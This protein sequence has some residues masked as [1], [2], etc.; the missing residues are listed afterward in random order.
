MDLKE[1][2]T[3]LPYIGFGE[4]R[5]GG[6]IENQDSWGYE[7]TPYGLLITVCDGMGGGPGGKTASSI[8]VDAIKNSVKEANSE[9]AIINIVIKAIRNANMAIIEKT[10]E[11]PALKGMGSTCLVLLINEKSAIAAHVGD[12]RIYQFRGHRKVFRTFDHSM[13]FELVKKKVIT[14]EQAR[15]SAQ[16][17][18]ITRALGVKPDVEVDVRQLPYLKG[19]RFML[20]SDGIHGTMPE[21][22][23]IELATSRKT[24]L[25]VIVDS[26]ASEVDNI[27]HNNGGGHDN[28]TTV[29]IET[30]TKSKLISKMDKHLRLVI[31]ILSIICILSIAF[32]IKHAAT[33][34]SL[35][36]DYRDNTTMI[37]SLKA[38]VEKMETTDI[39][40]NR[41]ISKLEKR[42]PSFEKKLESLK[43][44]DSTLKKQ[45]EKLKDQ[46]DK[47][48]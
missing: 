24:N 14:E 27:G 46:I 44:A 17:N 43:D 47:I 1:I 18:V 3:K 7:D 16:S 8:A 31:L 2:K 29:I 21:K 30:K 22:D 12:S 28:L 37:T 34:K 40:I 39:S 48:K 23:L 9:N 5:I 36:K 13:V 19:D 6:R 4:S 45:I 11:D 20:C 25:G 33:N 38:Q 26:L 35:N 15:L 32:N 42:S 41:Q 10:N